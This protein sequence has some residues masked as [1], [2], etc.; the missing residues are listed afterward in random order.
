MWWTMK[1]IYQ[2]LCDA[3]MAWITYRDVSIYMLNVKMLKAGLVVTAIVA[4]VVHLLLTA[5]GAPT[6]PALFALLFGIIT[7]MALSWAAR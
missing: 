3:A 5:L 7:S 1:T 6:F 2:I 4:V